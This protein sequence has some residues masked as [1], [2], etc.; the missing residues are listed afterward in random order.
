MAHLDRTW[1]ALVIAVVAAS[2]TAEPT[3]AATTDMLALPIPPSALMDMKA[4]APAAPPPPRP[5]MSVTYS[6]DS[7]ATLTMDGVTM[8][9]GLPD[10][11]SDSS[12]VQ[13]CGE[14]RERTFVLTPDGGAKYTSTD[15]SGQITITSVVACIGHNARY[16]RLLP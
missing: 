5:T 15:P 10:L 1:I 8:A 7:G 6:P 14:Q 4:T 16:P 9:T 3:T 13:A 11:V 2:R 12:N